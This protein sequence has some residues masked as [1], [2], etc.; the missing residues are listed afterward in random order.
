MRVFVA[1]DVPVT[2]IQHVKRFEIRRA[3]SDYREKSREQSRIFD[4]PIN[5]KG[6]GLLTNGA[7]GENG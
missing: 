4:G 6:G 5:G 3:L 1:N 2:I 7:L